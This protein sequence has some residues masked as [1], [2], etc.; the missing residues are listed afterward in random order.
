MAMPCADTQSGLPLAVTPSTRGTS[1]RL[2]PCRVGYQVP[3]LLLLLL[4][5]LAARTSPKDPKEAAAAALA[6]TSAAQA[7][8]RSGQLERLGT[9][10]V[11]EM[12]A[13]MAAGMVAAAPVEDLEQ[14]QMQLIQHMSVKKIKNSL[15]NLGE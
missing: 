13:G 4:P 15:A 7:L 14:A 2:I 11:A 10:R 1:R 5:Y 12:A 3:A 8:G 6:A 9:Q